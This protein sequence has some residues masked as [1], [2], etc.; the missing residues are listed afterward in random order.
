MSRHFVGK[1]EAGSIS[2]EP[3]AGAWTANRARDAWCS[4]PLTLARSPCCA[5]GGRSDS[6]IM[7]EGLT[8]AKALGMT[9]PQS[10]LLRADQVIQ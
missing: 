6:V 5:A 2:S 10:I 1:H 7:S 4:P 3:P 8:L 9:I